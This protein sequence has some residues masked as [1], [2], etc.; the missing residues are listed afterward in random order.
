[1][2]NFEN[3]IRDGKLASFINDYG[4]ILWVF[5]DAD[6]YPLGS[7]HSFLEVAQTKQ[8]LQCN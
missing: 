4:G 7:V 1:M 5:P 8:K 3:L 2:I 6:L